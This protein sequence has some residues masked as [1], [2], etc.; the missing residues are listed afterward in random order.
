MIGT[1]IIYIDQ[2][3]NRKCLHCKKLF[4]LDENDLLHTI[5]IKCT[6]KYESVTPEGKERLKVQRKIEREKK[7][8]DLEKK[9]EE[10]KRQERLDVVDKFMELNKASIE[11]NRKRNREIAR[12]NQQ[13]RKARENEVISD[14]TVT[15]WE[16][17]KE[18]FS[19]ICAY[20]GCDNDLTQ[21]HF[22]PV[23]KAGPYTI[24][25]IIPVCLSCNSSKHNKDFD[26]WYPYFCNYSKER[27]DKVYLYLNTFK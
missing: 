15:Q 23:S 8:Q 5:C 20:C 9:K 19:Q 22:I 24:D 18:F 6:L 25:N 21:D 17:V 16:N 11:S 27:E 4:V 7:R 14:F 12:N 2:K 13:L 3:P 26:K 1:R 10:E